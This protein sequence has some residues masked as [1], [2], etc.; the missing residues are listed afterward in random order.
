MVMHGKTLEDDLI[1][2]VTK[3]VKNPCANLVVVASQFIVAKNP[4]TKKGE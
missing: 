3:V 4:F 1:E 2:V